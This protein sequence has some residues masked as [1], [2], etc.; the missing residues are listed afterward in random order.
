MT[1]RR[2]AQVMKIAF[3]KYTSLFT[4]RRHFTGQSLDDLNE[5]F[6]QHGIKID[7]NEHNRKLT[8]TIEF[9]V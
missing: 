2:H 3:R 4:S 1:L 9:I 5:V 7:T 8:I 6:L